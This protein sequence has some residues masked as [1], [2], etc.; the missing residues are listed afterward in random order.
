[1]DADEYL[2]TVY[3][4]DGAAGLDAE[5]WKDS[6]GQ[7]YGVTPSDDYTLNGYFPRIKMINDALK[8]INTELIGL[9]T[10]LLEQNA[11][12]KVLETTIETSID[13]IQEVEEDFLNLT[14]FYPDEIQEDDIAKVV[15]EE[16]P[17]KDED[18]NTQTI[19]IIDPGI[20]NNWWTATDLK[21]TKITAAPWTQKIE[22][23]AQPS[24]RPL[25][26]KVGN[27]GLKEL[28]EL[29]GVS[30]SYKI[31]KDTDY[32]GLYIDFDYIQEKTYKLEY[33]FTPS[34]N[35]IERIGGHN[36]SFVTDYEIFI[37]DAG[38]KIKSFD[39]YI[40]YG[41]LQGHT[42][43]VTVIGTF[44]ATSETDTHPYLFI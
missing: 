23:Q 14:G 30:N 15:F 6:D 25:A 39:S 33:T 28:T 13:G 16:R 31:T 26:F 34:S 9:N 11:E 19:K 21:G 8:P 24:D 22:I 18:G 12:K 41:F 4:M 32:S 17:V 35:A 20:G 29:T 43:K 2:D 37:T 40:E 3:H 10:D 27:L 1:M 5:L 42:Y 44:D 7:N 38:T 36:Q